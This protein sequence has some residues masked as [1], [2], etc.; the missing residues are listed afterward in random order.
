MTGDICDLVL[1]E[2]RG[3]LGNRTSSPL[4]SASSRL[5]SKWCDQGMMKGEPVTPISSPA[6]CHNA[7]M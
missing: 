2:R 1:M 5:Q 6:A 7:E 3:C 4:S